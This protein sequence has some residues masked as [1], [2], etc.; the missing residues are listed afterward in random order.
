MCSTVCT[1]LCYVCLVSPPPPRVQLVTTA[2]RQL[3]RRLEEEVRELQ[4]TLERED[5][6][7]HFRELDAG[8]LRHKLAQLSFGK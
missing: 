6:V 7:M 3:R 8:A 4:A 1:V 5:D 2:R